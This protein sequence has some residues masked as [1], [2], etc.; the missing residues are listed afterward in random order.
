M[1]FVRMIKW[2]ESG[3]G[4]VLPEDAE[5][6]PVLTEDGWEYRYQGVAHW[7]VEETDA[8]LK[9]RIKKALDPGPS[10]GERP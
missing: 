4:D 3:A 7:A 8:E 5:L 9:A 10:A 6:V 2:F 1:T